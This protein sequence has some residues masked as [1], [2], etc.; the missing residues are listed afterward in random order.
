V[1]RYQ[2]FIS[3][4]EQGESLQ[5]IAR[6]CPWGSLSAEDREQ[7]LQEAKKRAHASPSS[8]KLM[9][10][11]VQLT[12]Q[13]EP[14]DFLRALGLYVSCEG[15][16]INQKQQALVQM[17][18]TLEKLSTSLD[19]RDSD[20]KRFKHYRAD[21]HALRAR[22][23]LEDNE[24]HN[25]RQQYSRALEIYQEYGFR[26]KAAAIR[27]HLDDL[28]AIAS[29]RQQL[30]PLDDL[31]ARRVTLQGECNQLWDQI[32]QQR[33]ILGD[34]HQAVAQ[35]ETAKAELDQELTEK[36]RQLE[37]MKQEISAKKV[38]RL[39]VNEEVQRSEAGLYFL[40]SLPRA[41]TA[42]LWVEVVRLALQQGEIDDLAR[43][44]LERLAIECPQEALPLLA[45][46]AARAPHPLRVPD[47]LL[48]ARMDHWMV[49]MARARK[50][51]K[52]EPLQAA[53][54][55]VGAWE[56]FFAAGETK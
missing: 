18:Q 30:L 25:A 39:A 6:A 19:G 52:S 46:V 49:S 21:Y 2:D 4:V 37:D 56:S 28:Q 16:T 26:R 36:Q 24:V 34:L 38:E 33:P 17:D 10:T 22:I 11:L 54:E 35:A 8:T 15:V 27:K 44:A 7:L 50:L 51:V 32:E 20:V 47:A 5:S 43:Q 29:Q 23:H 41:A 31:T 55:L 40:L 53:E 12:H 14:W 13:K 42:P 1:S 45:E 48:A 3:L 9:V